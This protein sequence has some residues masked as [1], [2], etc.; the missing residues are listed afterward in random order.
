MHVTSCTVG[1]DN[2]CLLHCLT[3]RQEVIEKLKH[4]LPDVSCVWDVEKLKQVSDE[5]LQGLNIFQRFLANILG[6]PAMYQK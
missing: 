1:V 5:R 6:I 3:K 2:D 4:S